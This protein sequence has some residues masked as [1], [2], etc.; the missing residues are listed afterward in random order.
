MLYGGNYCRTMERDS[1]PCWI[2][3]C[4]HQL[5]SS[6][7]QR[8]FRQNMLHTYLCR[9]HA[10]VERVS[11]IG[12]APPK[13]I[14][15][16]TCVIDG[17]LIACFRHGNKQVHR[18]KAPRVHLLQSTRLAYEYDCCRTAAWVGVDNRANTFNNSH[19][20]CGSYIHHA[21]L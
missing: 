8:F 5:R 17:D 16:V 10:F 12:T 2:V 7:R 19:Q 14:V 13:G 4:S 21:S 20:G 1:K 3:H 18:T 15:G 9:H 11:R 6:A